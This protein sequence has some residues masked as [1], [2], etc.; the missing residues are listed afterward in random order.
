M[1][2]TIYVSPQGNDE[3]D[4]TQPTNPHT[5]TAGPM[6]TLHAAR[7]KARR[8]HAETNDIITIRMQGGRYEIDSPL[9]LT[10]QDSHTHFCA[11]ESK[12]AIVDAGTQIENF[13]EETL[14]GRTVWTADVTDIIKKR[15]YFRQLFV[16][17]RRAIRARLPKNDY[18]WMKEVPGTVPGKTSY[19]AKDVQKHRFIA[20][21][22]DFK[23]WHNLNDCDV[24]VLH[25]WSEDRRAVAS[26]DPSTN[27]VTLAEDTVFILVDDNT[28]V[29]ARYYIDNVFE[30]L[31]EPGEWYLDRSQQKLY[32][33]PRKGETL[34]NCEAYAAGGHSIVSIQGD[35]AEDD[36]VTDL[37]FRHIVFRHSDWRDYNRQSQAANMLPGAI[38]LT[39]AHRCAFIGCRITHC[40][41]YG[42]DILHGCS[43]CLISGCELSDLGA[44]A[45]KLNGA[46][47]NGD[48]ALRTGEITIC[49]NHCHALGR[50]HHG[51]AAICIKHAYGVKAVHN[52]IHDCF[53]T[54]IS[55]GWVWGCWESVARDNHI[56]K[57]HIHDIGQGLLNDMGA[58]YLL[59]IQPGT[60]IRGN[61]IHNVKSRKY[62]GWAIYLDEGS[63]YMVIEHNI[64]HDTTSQ[65]FHIHFGNENMIRNNIW[66]FSGEGIFSLERGP[67]C[68][69]P[70]KGITGDGT[71]VNSLTVERN[72][73]ITDDTPI[74]L[75]GMAQEIDGDHSG[76]L[77][78]HPFTSERNLFFDIN[79][80]PIRNANGGHK[81]A[82]EGYRE[83]FD[84][85]QWQKIGYDRFSIVDDPKCAD[86]ASRDF[87]L[88]DDSPAYSLG[89]TPIH[90]RDIGPR[91]E[92]HHTISDP[93][94]Y[95]D[96]EIKK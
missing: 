54:A 11:S 80:K 65:A 53:Y 60:T 12:P 42:I 13:K 17:D 7:D 22:G 28:P 77:Q 69:W 55:C 39:G 46:N 43:N 45:L 56:E 19:R 38:N 30:G 63:S 68:S 37:H 84:W 67:S 1:Q 79:D 75:G 59:G 76:A 44:G 14:H 95:K 31:T 27:E 89:F 29:F 21:E 16:N 72:I 26:F 25:W 23:A 87:T 83:I 81:I 36:L 93:Q 4:G 47:A 88:A 9:E 5:A 41:N 82:R 91:P 8:L 20:H 32:Y 2:T 40:G 71:M 64:C 70:K 48:R 49:D 85:E 94:Y 10:A 92:L 57:N 35:A 15:G 18:F 78:N 33:L 74:Y 58:I 3:F 86:I 90:T 66:A 62:G 73:F 96:P 24:V 6:R 34:Q 51:A 61:L 50:V 52:H